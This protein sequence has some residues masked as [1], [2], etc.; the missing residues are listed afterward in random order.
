MMINTFKLDTVDFAKILADETRQQIMA[1]CCCRWASVSELQS[2][3]DVSQP[4]VSHHL[5]VLRS[6]GLVQART[7]GRQV[8]YRLEQDQVL[9]CCESLIDRFNPD[10][11][12]GVAEGE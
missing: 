4:T 11:E 8:F 10:S 1:L 3:L 12:A 7:E 5:G 9:S 2:Q 6:A